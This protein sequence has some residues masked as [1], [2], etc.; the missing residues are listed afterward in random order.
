MIKKF[1]A[2]MLLAVMVAAAQT[3]QA[4]DYITY[5]GHVSHY[6]WMHPVRDGETIGTTGRGEALEAVIIN[7]DGGIR[8]R[9]HV[10]NEGWQDWVYSG[11]VAG[12]TGR[13]LHMEAIRIK[14]EGRA[15]DYYDVYYRAHVQNEGWLGWVKNG[16][17]A[18]TVG[19]GLRL[20]A[21]QIRLVEKGS[22]FGY[23]NHR[24]RHYY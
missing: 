1:F 11:Q 19:E 12:T 16:E 7:F 9:A 15:A 4:Y 21:L 2:V 20:E 14:L 10:Q 17:V 18:G 24:P 5:Q 8:Y 3:A 23:D 6:G 13:G 22:H